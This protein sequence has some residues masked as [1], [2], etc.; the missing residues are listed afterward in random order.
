M[1]H[2]QIEIEHKP[3]ESL[4]SMVEQLH[5]EAT[6]HQTPAKRTSKRTS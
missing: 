3:T 4:R 5:S 1:I 2:Y 6:R